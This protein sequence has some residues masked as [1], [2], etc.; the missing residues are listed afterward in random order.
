M[1]DQRPVFSVVIPTYN[2]SAFL[3]QAIKSVLCQT[4]QEF[5]VVVVDDGSTDNT[6]RIVRSFCDHRLRY[7]FKEN[8]E[9]SIA[10]NYGVERCSGEYVNFLDS[11]DYFYP[12]HLQLAYDSLKERSFPELL[13]FGYEYRNCDGTVRMAEV[14]PGPELN[15]KLIFENSLTGACLF[16]KRHVLEG[17]TFIPHRDAVI[18][19]DWYLWLRL[20]ARFPIHSVHKI[21]CVVRQHEQRSLNVLDASRIERSLLMIVSELKKDP[22]F[23]GYYG[24]S[25]P[26]FLC[27]CYSLIALHYVRVLKSVTLR[28]VLMAMK[29]Y[30]L[31]L[32]RR[33]FWAIVKNLI[34]QKSTS[35]DHLDAHS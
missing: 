15:K 29:A 14:M 30:P 6:A 33:R 17:L 8:E 23:L 21:S 19:E 7:F 10:R 34:F 28:Y 11:D 32:R 2:R 25:F 3:S 26:Y 27:E 9:R 13:H 35:H 1:K 4:F 18:S 16:I 31:F 12:H 24:Q 20:A 22:V 5:E